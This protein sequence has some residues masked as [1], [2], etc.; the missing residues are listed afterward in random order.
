MIIPKKRFAIPGQLSSF[1]ERQNLQ[2]DK[3]YSTTTLKITLTED[4]L[5][6]IFEDIINQIHTLT[7]EQ[8]D[9]IEEV[10]G[11]YPKYLFLVG[12]LGQCPLLKHKLETHFG[13]NVKIIC[14]TWAG[15][16]VMNGS[17]ML[18]LD[19]SLIRER[20]SKFTYGIEVD[21]IFQPDLHDDA[22][23][24][25]EGDKF[26]VKGVFKVFVQFG[27]PIPVDD[28]KEE[29]FIVPKGAQQLKVQ[30]LKSV[31]TD[32]KKANNTKVM[33]LAMILVDVS[34]SENQN[35]SVKMQF[36]KAEI[37]VSAEDARGHV[38]NVTV[39]FEAELL[40]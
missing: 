18:A 27:Q 21:E 13:N 5:R 20:K 28:V 35:I 1:I 26:L 16:A 8:I 2:H 6:N 11:Q 38:F 39:S 40:S 29:S 12:G 32:P 9:K 37:L 30:L 23:C 22:D 25:C 17:A 3:F 7:K 15:E 31:L 14:P 24:V 36:G 4:S 33:Q 10:H 19:P 34:E